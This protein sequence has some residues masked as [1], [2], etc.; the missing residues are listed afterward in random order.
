MASKI[1]A[2][3]ERVEKRKQIKETCR[4]HWIIEAALG[5][6]SEGVCKFCGER[7]IFLNIVEDT[8]SKEDLNRF[9]D[10][11]N[12]LAEDENDDDD[13]LEEGIGAN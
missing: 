1:G 7:R 13:N 10:K 5:P 12:L 9:F 11:V 6:T 3:L 8:E 4:H 2:V